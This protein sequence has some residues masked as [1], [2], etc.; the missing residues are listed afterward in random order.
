[1]RSGHHA[2][3]ALRAVPGFR[4][5]PKRVGRQVRVHSAL[6][7]RGKLVLPPFEVAKHPINKQDPLLLLL[8]WFHLYYLNIVR[9]EGA[10]HKFKQNRTASGERIDPEA[11][12]Q[13]LQA[14]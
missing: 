5:V 9:M 4:V 10:K 11:G 7:L 1:M 8:N 12:N 2:S 6:G 14:L 13:Y 3:G